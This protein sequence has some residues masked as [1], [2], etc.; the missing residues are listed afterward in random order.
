LHG[1]VVMFVPDG[2]HAVRQA[3]QPLHAAKHERVQLMTHGRQTQTH[4]PFTHVGNESFPF[5]AVHAGNLLPQSDS[6]LQACG[7]PGVVAA[8]PAI[9]V[10]MAARRTATKKKGD[11]DLERTRVYEC[12]VM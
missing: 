5:L 12:I 7:V 2:R 3:S 1:I 4:V 6:I 10:A 8:G 11:S 9:A